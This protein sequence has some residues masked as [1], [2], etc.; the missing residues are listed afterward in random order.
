MGVSLSLCSY[1]TLSES[2]SLSTIPGGA[3]IFAAQKGVRIIRV[4]SSFI[5]SSMADG[6]QRQRRQRRRPMCFSLVFI[7]TLFIMVFA[8]VVVV[9]CPVLC[10]ECAIRWMLWMF[11]L[12]QPTQPSRT[13]EN[14]DIQ[15]ICCW[16]STT[17]YFGFSPLLCC[18]FTWI[19]WLES[20]TI[21]SKR[22]KLCLSTKSIE[23]FV[24]SLARSLCLLF[25]VSQKLLALAALHLVGDYRTADGACTIFICRSIDFQ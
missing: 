16:T 6:Y 14:D 9:V 8:C 19:L 15:Y 4:T 13:A 24:R 2:L 5:R 1:N 23:S 25:Y 7:H 21:N 17:I 3:V 22:I 12:F 10:T 20:D 11:L 18:I